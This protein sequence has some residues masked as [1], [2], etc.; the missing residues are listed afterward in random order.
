[1]LKSGPGILSG[2]KYVYITVLFLLMAGFFSPL[3]SGESAEGVVY[4][5]L[6]LFVGLAA[7]PILYKAARDEKGRMLFLGVGVGL[8]ALSLVFVL[9]LTGRF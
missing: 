1:M 2:A 4:G 5:T 6:S 3:V 8:I 7:A 9:A